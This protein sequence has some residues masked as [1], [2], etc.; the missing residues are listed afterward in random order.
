MYLAVWCRLG[1]LDETVRRFLGLC[2]IRGFV[3]RRG[4]LPVGSGRIG[5]WAGLW[6]LWPTVRVLCVD[7]EW[8]VGK[9]GSH[10]LPDDE[11][12]QAA[13]AA[14]SSHVQEFSLFH[15]WWR[16]I[17]CPGLC[18]VVGRAAGLPVSTR[19]GRWARGGSE[20]RRREALLLLP[21]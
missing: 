2:L 20:G 4:S 19:G 9:C 10:A 14:P 7:K 17:A 11:P 18:R 1:W 16:L 6:S 5:E 13:S 15:P 21:G 3:Q 12:E 8:V